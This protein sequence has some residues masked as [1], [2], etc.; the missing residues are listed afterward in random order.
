VG[1]D[2]HGGC[3][4]RQDPRKPM[5]DVTSRS[6]RARGTDE[7]HVVRPA[8]RELHD[9]LPAQRR[10][11]RTTSAARRRPGDVRWQRDRPQARIPA[12]RANRS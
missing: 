11:E 6:H 5:Q 4:D 12:S 2:P 8:I 1:T 9:I 7:K 3:K 10:F